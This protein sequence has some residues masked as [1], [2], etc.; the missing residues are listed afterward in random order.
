MACG[1]TGNP[2]SEVLTC[3][4]PPRGRAG[5]TDTWRQMTAHV[6]GC[7][8][9]RT[10]LTCKSRQGAD[11]SGVSPCCAPCSSPRS[12]IWVFV[13]VTGLMAPLRSANGQHRARERCSGLDPVAAMT[14]NPDTGAWL[15]LGRFAELLDSTSAARV[16]SEWAVGAEAACLMDAA[17][18][19]PLPRP[20]PPRCPSRPLR[21]RHGPRLRHRRH[22]R[23]RSRSR[24]HRGG[25]SRDLLRHDHPRPRPRPRS[26]PV[27]G[28]QGSR[29]PCHLVA[30]RV[31]HD[32]L[33]DH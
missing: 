9:R 3:L 31:D 28:L 8:L 10:P 33:S 20:R 18:P 2:V 27:P 21:W 30:E 4:A 24:L 29:L 5:S 32:A 23:D 15:P 17:C 26:E 11:K 7:T 12:S 6:N 14:G 13:Q 16:L 19:R 22:F 1:I 25:P